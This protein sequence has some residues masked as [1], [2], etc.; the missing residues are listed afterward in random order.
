MGITIDIPEGWPKVGEL[1]G[2]E[3]PLTSE[4]LEKL[5][6]QERRE[7]TVDV[8]GKGKI[9]PFRFSGDGDDFGL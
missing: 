8:P 1:R 2:K 7:L 5:S 4:S 3:V 9:R 6:E